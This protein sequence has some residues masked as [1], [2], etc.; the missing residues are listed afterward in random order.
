MPTR[1]KSKKEKLI[2]K[3]KLNLKE[4]LESVDSCNDYQRGQVL[5]EAIKLTCERI[6][7]LENIQ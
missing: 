3:Y 6:D 2:E 5:L 4:L 7:L 1:R